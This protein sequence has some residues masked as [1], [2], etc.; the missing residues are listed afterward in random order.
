V[1]R[2]R[3]AFGDIVKDLDPAVDWLFVPG[4]HPHQGDDAAIAVIDLDDNQNVMS[5]PLHMFITQSMMA[6]HQIGVGDDVFMMGLFADV[7][8]SMAHPAKARFGNISMMA[9]SHIPIAQPNHTATKS[10]YVLDMHSR[11]GFSGSPVFFYRTIG[12]DLTYAN[13]LEMRLNEPSLKNSHP[14]TSTVEDSGLKV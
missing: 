13:T 4:G 8:A 5:I 2:I 9:S 3:T 12:A 7:A 11:S 14:R 1:I 10:S 6:R